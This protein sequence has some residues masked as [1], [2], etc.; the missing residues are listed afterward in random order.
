MRLGNWYTCDT[1]VQTSR[2]LLHKCTYIQGT[3]EKIQVCKFLIIH[4]LISASCSDNHLTKTNFWFSTTFTVITDR[5]RS[6]RREVIFSLCQCTPVGGGG[7]S[8]RGTLPPSPLRDRTAHGVL[9][10][11]RSV[12]LLRSR[13][14]NFLLPCGVAADTL[15]R[16]RVAFVVF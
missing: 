11:R 10:K 2:N 16:R 9:D 14:R 6:T 13:K 4:T 7:T 8:A 3:T 15:N 1:A 12:C 5:V